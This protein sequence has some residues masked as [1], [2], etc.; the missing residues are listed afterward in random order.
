MFNPADLS[1]LS[2]PMYHSTDEPDRFL[3][4][5]SFLSAKIDLSISCLF[6]PAKKSATATSVR[7]KR[8]FSEV[9]IFA[10]DFKYIKETRSVVVATA[11]SWIHRKGGGDGLTD[12]AELCRRP[13]G[14]GSSS[15]PSAATTEESISTI[16][17][18]L[19]MDDR[20][21]GD[22]RRSED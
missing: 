16:E 7:V 11:R 20:I 1:R 9:D 5:R 2:H 21:V 15:S 10:S 3:A 17:E 13:C 4:N 14:F 19:C 12:T 22:D 18:R 8:R 6:L